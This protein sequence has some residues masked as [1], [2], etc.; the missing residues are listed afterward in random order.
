M[1]DVFSIAKKNFYMIVCTAAVFITGC[2]AC[3]QCDSNSLPSATPYSV[4][5]AQ[6]AAHLQLP[7]NSPY[8][9][10]SLSIDRQQKVFDELG[11]YVVSCRL[12]SSGYMVD[13]RYKVIDPNKA[14]PLFTNKTD[15]HIIDQATG[16]I[17]IVP[18]PPKVGKLR[19]TRQPKKDKIYFMFFANPGKYIKTDN[20][21]TFVCG[22][23]RIEDVV[24]R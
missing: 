18:N 6:D 15:P 8:Y 23:H 10:D 24:V 14:A 12:S 20:K 4:Q 1:S 13:F 2:S 9:S 5:A 19:T 22:Q 11:I 17:F 7:V 21:L 16:A 3:K